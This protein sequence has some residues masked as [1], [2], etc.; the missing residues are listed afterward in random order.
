[1][2]A[3][4]R[5]EK[6]SGASQHS[7][8]RELPDTA[9]AEH[10]A[11][12]GDF[13]GGLASAARSDDEKNSGASQHSSWRKLPDTACAEH[14]AGEDDF[15]RRLYQP[16]FFVAG[17]SRKKVAEPA[18]TVRGE[19]CQLTQHALVQGQHPVHTRRQLTIM[20]HHDETGAHFLI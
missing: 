18:N 19:N 11:G 2:D 4:E 1:M 20:R 13:F 17:R 14:Q 16:R 8:W 3:R 6:N 10:Q 12:E 5:S 9:C 15:L 7:S